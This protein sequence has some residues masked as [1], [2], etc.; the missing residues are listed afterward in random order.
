MSESAYEC[1]HCG[2]RFVTGANP[3]S[4]QP[5]NVEQPVSPECPG[6]GGSDVKDLKL[7]PAYIRFLLGL[8]RPT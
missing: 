2:V 1:N 6:C 8:M 4:M 7:P 5:A 3:C